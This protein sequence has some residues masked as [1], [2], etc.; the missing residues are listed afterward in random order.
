[1]AASANSAAN[2][3]VTQGCRQKTTPTVSTYSISRK[4]IELIDFAPR[5]NE[6]AGAKPA[7]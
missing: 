7:F 5:Q 2:P 4:S 6:D 3:E 1:M